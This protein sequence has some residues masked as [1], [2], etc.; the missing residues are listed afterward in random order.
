M[1]LGKSWLSKFSILTSFHHYR[2][3]DEFLN[4]LLQEECDLLYSISD[5]FV[6]E[7]IE[8]EFI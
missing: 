2:M 8:K 7:L 4:E 5:E 3:A 6:N 1:I